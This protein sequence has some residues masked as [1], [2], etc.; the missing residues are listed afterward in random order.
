M[1]APVLDRQRDWL[2]WVLVRAGLAD[3]LPWWRISDMLDHIDQVVWLEEYGIG[4]R[5]KRWPSAPGPLPQAWPGYSGAELEAI[6][7]RT[8]AGLLE[9][10]ERGLP[11]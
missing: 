7:A 2:W 11:S 1:S 3:I 10:A 8:V 9:L 4:D 5:P 6:E